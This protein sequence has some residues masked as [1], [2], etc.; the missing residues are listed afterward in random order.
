ML[1]DGEK[2]AEK[3]LDQHH[4]NTVEELRCFNLYT[5]AT[6]RLDEWWIAKGQTVSEKTGR[7][8]FAKPLTSITALGDSPA[9]NEYLRALNFGNDVPVTDGIVDV[10]QASF[11]N[12]K[13]GFFVSSSRNSFASSRLRKR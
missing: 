4:G 1:S 5:A 7:Y 2:V 13:R 9:D 10:S 8:Y 12:G 6:Y 11:T 3:E